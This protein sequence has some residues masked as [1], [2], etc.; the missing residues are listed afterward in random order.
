MEEDLYRLVLLFTSHLC[1]Y[2]LFSHILCSIPYLQLVRLPVNDKNYGVKLK[3][4]AWDYSFRLQ[5]TGI[6]CNSTLARLWV[7]ASTGAEGTDVS[8]HKNPLELLLLQ[9]LLLVASSSCEDCY[10]FGNN[11]FV[12]YVLVIN[13]FFSDLLWR[14]SLLKLIYFSYSGELTSIK[15]WTTSQTRVIVWKTHFPFQ[16]RFSSV[17]HVT[18]STDNCHQL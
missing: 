17:I 12:F 9:E 16:K 3:H 8:T 2:L 11:E 14:N 13:K 15:F 10:L 7:L 6:P 4:G 5:Q 1:W 18:M